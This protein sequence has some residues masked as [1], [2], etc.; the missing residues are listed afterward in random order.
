MARTDFTTP[1]LFVEQPLGEG[2]ILTLTPEQTNYLVNVLR[3]GPPARVFLFNGRDGEF[4]ASIAAASRKALTLIVGAQTR[5]QETPPDLEY[6]FAP[7]KHARLDYVAQKAVEMGARRLRPILTRRTQVSRINIERLTANAIEACEQCGVIWTP[8]V[9]PLEPLEKT[10]AEWPAERLLVFCDEEAPQASPLD[11]LSRVTAAA[12][13]GLIIGPEGGFER[14]GARRNPRRPPRAAAEPRT[15]GAA[16]RHRGGRRTDADPG[17]AR[18]LAQTSATIAGRRSL[19]SHFVTAAR[20]VAATLSFHFG[21]RYERRVADAAKVRTTG[22]R[23]ARVAGDP[24]PGMPDRG[25]RWA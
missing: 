14:A 3:L 24:Y 2:E 20:H 7:L 23:R 10:L 5:P 17:D 16:R 13:I 4:A 9:S 6:L 11:A 25:G 19:D 12:G 8:E 18:R 21:S 15:E 1:R 22:H